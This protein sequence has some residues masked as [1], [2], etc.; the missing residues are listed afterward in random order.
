MSKLSSLVDPKDVMAGG[1]QR[2]HAVDAVYLAN[3]SDPSGMLSALFIASPDVPMVSP[4]TTQ[5]GPTP[6][7]DDLSPLPGDMTGFAFNLYVSRRCVP[8]FLVY[9]LIRRWFFVCQLQQRMEYELHFLVSV[10]GRRRR[11]QVS[12]R[13][14]VDRTVAHGTNSTM[15]VI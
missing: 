12:L 4:V 14:S 5:S 3:S 1:S 9:E 2:Q 10:C 6:L 11:L 13:S 8:P 15:Q 7:T